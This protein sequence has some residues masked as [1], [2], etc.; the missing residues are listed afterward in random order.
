MGYEIGFLVPG[1][2]DDRLGDELPPLQ[3]T[4]KQ[5]AAWRRIVSRA[6]QEIGAA[7]EDRYPTHLELWLK[8]PAMQL[9][10]EGNSA[11]I[12]LPYWYTATAASAHGA[13]ATAY[14]LARIVEA[15]TGMP[16]VDYE[17]DQA[18]QDDGLSRA[19]AR[20]RG[21][22]QHVRALVEG[23]VPQAGHVSDTNADES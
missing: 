14:A 2:D 16:A 23:G 22:G 11:S 19:V 5:E 21:V 18:V 9:W 13:I 7:E 1:Q 8:D 3:L 17:V 12:E 15:E 6:R 10:Y 20:Y 4:D